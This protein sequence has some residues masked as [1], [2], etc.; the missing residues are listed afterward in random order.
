VAQ[1]PVGSGFRHFGGFGAK[2]STEKPRERESRR[3]PRRLRGVSHVAS[4]VRS[5]EV[6]KAGLQNREWR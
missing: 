2:G 6:G 3:V 5:S 1:D 4:R